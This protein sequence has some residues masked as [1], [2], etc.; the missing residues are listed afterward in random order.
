[1]PVE[2]RCPPGGA[3]E[4]GLSR[5]GDD[6]TCNGVALE[7]GTTIC[8]ILFVGESSIYELFEGWLAPSTV[9]ICSPRDEESVGSDIGGKGKHGWGIDVCCRDVEP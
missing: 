9:S 2:A 5:A 4:V 6:A 8:A 1:M 7:L 3:V